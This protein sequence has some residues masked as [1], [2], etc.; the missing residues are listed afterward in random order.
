MTNGNTVEFETVHR[1]FEEAVEAL[2]QLSGLMG[3]LREAEK[4]KERSA[5]AISNASDRLQ[6]TSATL[7][8]YCELLRSALDSTL[9]ALQSAENLATGAELTAIRTAVTSN[10]EALT[11]LV[12]N[13]DS[14]NIK[15]ADLA[16]R[17][18]T[19][20][21]TVETIQNKIDGDLAE[22]QRSRDSA[23]TELTE[24][25]N[26]LD[27]LETRLSGLPSRVRRKHDLDSL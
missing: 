15:L 11:H 5:A 27:T 8:S 10:R 3:G 22:A 13:E 23:L 26:R 7:A 18:S 19:I 6:E 12:E 24:A 25:K 4:V 16:N 2:K 20:A 17:Q 21:A 1:R 9:Q 14:R